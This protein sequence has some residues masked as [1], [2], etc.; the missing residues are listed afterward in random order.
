MSQRETRSAI[1]DPQ[2]DRTPVWA[3]VFG[4]VRKRMV[5]MI[6]VIGLLGISAGQGTRSTP[7]AG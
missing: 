7:V 2:T 6:A 5:D 3:L 1:K 4:I